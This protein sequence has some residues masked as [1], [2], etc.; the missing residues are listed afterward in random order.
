MFV[1][2]S[3]WRTHAPDASFDDMVAE[4]PRNLSYLPVAAEHI[5]VYTMQR[6]HML[7]YVWYTS[8]SR[9]QRVWGNS[10]YVMLH[11]EN[12]PAA[13]YHRILRAL[14]LMRNIAQHALTA[15]RDQNEAMEL[16]VR[17][18]CKARH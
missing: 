17:S 4:L 1:L 3:L 13:R 11:R 7:G 9:S 14:P 5:A 18:G 6:D 10:S 15:K 2:T 12:N 8:L 16:L